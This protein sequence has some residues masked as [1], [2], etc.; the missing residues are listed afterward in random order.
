MKSRTSM[1]ALVSAAALVA[2]AAGGLAT[3]DAGYAAPA[4]VAAGAVAGSAVA[5][6]QVVNNLGLSTAQ[7]KNWQSW[8]KETD[9]YSGPIDGQLGT[10]SWMAAQELWNHMGLK[11]GTVDGIVGTNT[12]KA[13]QRYL[14]GFGYGL[15]VDG[16]AGT[17][18]VNAFRAFCS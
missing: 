17:K 11:A 13:L 5:A 3:A 18:T 8:L 10:A 2:V 4:P 9:Y 15:T 1:R 12:V 14:N 7:A 16:I 6:P